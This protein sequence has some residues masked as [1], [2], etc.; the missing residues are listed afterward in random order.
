MF[1]LLLTHRSRI[2]V[3]APPPR[4]Y[5]PYL[6]HI[7]HPTQSLDDRVTLLETN[8]AFAATQ[9]AV[10]AREVEFLTTLRDLKAALSTSGDGAGGGGG[11]AATTSLKS[12]SSSSSSQIK[13]LQSE[14][15]ALKA[16]L[17]KQEYRIQHLLHAMETK[18]IWK[19]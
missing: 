19:N 12:S 6:W 8:A 4:S 1:A 18:Q 10:R 5:L 17:A 9:E 7:I 11:D 16:K 2:H 15:A 14:N 13:T 3:H